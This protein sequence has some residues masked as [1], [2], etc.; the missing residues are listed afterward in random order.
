MPVLPPQTREMSPV[1][2]GEEEPMLSTDEVEDHNKAIQ[3]AS[4]NTQGKMARKTYEVPSGTE[5]KIDS[6]DL[7]PESQDGGPEQADM[8]SVAETEEERALEEAS[9]I[10][11]EEEDLDDEEEEEDEEEYEFDEGLDP[12]GEMIDEE[13]VMERGDSI[14]A[15]EIDDEI[16]YV[17]KETG[18]KQNG[19]SMAPTGSQSHIGN[20]V[21]QVTG[22]KN[23][24]GESEDDDEDGY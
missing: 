13:G 6:A 20:F 1:H 10:E 2:E 9:G 23:R 7:P 17:T 5:E 14:L 16:S 12:E 11:D 8:S 19:T 18:G 24:I 22:S 3:G 4:V 21:F 15:D